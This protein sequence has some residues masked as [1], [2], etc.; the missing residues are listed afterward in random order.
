MRLY[1]KKG[2]SKQLEHTL[3]TVLCSYFPFPCESAQIPRFSAA[4]LPRGVCRQN[5]ADT[6]LAVLVIQCQCSIYAERPQGLEA[7]SIKMGDDNAIRAT[8]EQHWTAVTGILRGE[9]GKIW[10]V[11]LCFFILVR[12]LVLLKHQG[13]CGL[14]EE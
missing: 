11:L 5:P 2:S 12:S 8:D 3:Q 1:Y 10:V 14:K 13:T 7:C 9:I 6:F 4:E